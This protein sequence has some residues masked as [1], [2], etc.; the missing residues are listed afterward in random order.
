MHCNPGVSAVQLHKVPP[1]GAD[2]LRSSILA[3]H[4]HRSTGLTLSYTSPFTLWFDLLKQLRTKSQFCR[5][6]IHKTK[7]RPLWV[8]GPNRADLLLIGQVTFGGGHPPRCRPPQVRSWQ[9]ADSWM[10]FS[11]AKIKLSPSGFLVVPWWPC[12]A[13]GFGFLFLGFGQT[14][15]WRIHRLR[16]RSA[17]LNL[18]FNQRVAAGTLFRY[19]V[20]EICL[21][22]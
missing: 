3:A 21:K 18:H 14:W 20:G 6:Q 2:T 5:R 22:S 16:S 7:T 9:T 13:S 12:T 11:R 4:R 17:S 15:C 10:V 8:G 19:L 1:G